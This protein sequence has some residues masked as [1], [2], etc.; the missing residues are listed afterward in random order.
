MPC[1][2]SRVGARVARLPPLLAHQ[3]V[4]LVVD[5][6]GPLVLDGGT[7]DLELLLAHRIEQEAHPIRL[8]PENFF[9][10]GGRHRLVVVG[11]VLVGGAIHV[12]TGL[13]D[14]PH[15]LLIPH[16]LGALEHHVFEE[17]G[18]TGLADRLA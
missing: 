2:D 13:V 9:Q 18:K 16:V 3:T 8:Q 4:R 12:A 10:L 7:L 11:A 6:L 17:V 1:Y 5:A 14:D 15:V